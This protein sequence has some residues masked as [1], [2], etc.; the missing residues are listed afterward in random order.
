MCG[1]NRGKS[2]GKERTG[3]EAGKEERAQ[4]GGVVPRAVS[5]RCG[6][7]AS[8]GLLTGRNVSCRFRGAWGRRGVESR[9]AGRGR[10]EKTPAAAEKIGRRRASGRAG[11]PGPE[12]RDHDGSGRTARDGGE[13]FKERLKISG[14]RG[15][16]ARRRFPEADGFRRSGTF[17]RAPAFRG[18][19]IGRSLPGALCRAFCPVGKTKPGAQSRGVCSARRASRFQAFRIS[20]CFRGA[21]AAVPSFLVFFMAVSFPP[22]GV[23]SDAVSAAVPCR[24]ACSWGS[25]SF[26]VASAPASF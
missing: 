25:S 2:H 7:R 11:E 13:K 10:G 17:L 9:S 1:R 12:G 18:L 6:G 8:H 3:R 22:V 21:L 4:A 14:G 16:S 15:T 24:T 26:G 5:G 23:P 20:G 19:F